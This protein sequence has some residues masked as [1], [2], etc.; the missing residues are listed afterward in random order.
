MIDHRKSNV[1]IYSI[2][3]ETELIKDHYGLKYWFFFI[4]RC[5]W[6]HIIPPNP[7][8]LIGNKGHGKKWMNAQTG[9][10]LR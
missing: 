10:L 1:L 6:L 9:T 3:T 8:K 7:L 5:N 2:T 4:M